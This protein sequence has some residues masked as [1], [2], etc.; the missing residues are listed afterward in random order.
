MVRYWRFG[1]ISSLCGRNERP[2][3]GFSIQPAL[4]FSSS[5][6]LKSLT[7][8]W[9]RSTMWRDH[10]TAT[11][12]PVCDVIFLK[13]RQPWMASPGHLC[14]KIASGMVVETMTIA[15][16]TDKWWVMYTPLTRNK[17]GRTSP[18]PAIVQKSS[19]NIRFMGT[20]NFPHWYYLHGCDWHV[21][22]WCE[23]STHDTMW[24]HPNSSNVQLDMRTPLETRKTEK[25]K[26]TMITMKYI[27]W[28][29]KKSIF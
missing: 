8:F 7:L 6:L 22:L 13:K 18:L 27:S 4:N 25:K 17:D 26:K 23:H 2:S 24:S 16:L 12:S 9:F 20:A 21:E 3:S 28:K 5:W 19:Q 11:S 15:V 14:V 1:I 10:A 29:E